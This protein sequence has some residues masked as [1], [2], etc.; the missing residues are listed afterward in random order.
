[1]RGGETLEQTFRRPGAITGECGL[2]PS[3][4]IQIFIT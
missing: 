1:V 2:T 3:N 4:E